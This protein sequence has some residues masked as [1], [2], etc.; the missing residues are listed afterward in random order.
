M[1]IE[2]LAWRT[3]PRKVRKLAEHSVAIVC[4]RLEVPIP[5]VEFYESPR[6]VTEVDEKPGVV[7]LR[8]TSDRP[9]ETL[10]CAAYQLRR[11]WCSREVDEYPDR[12]VA[13]ARALVR[14]LIPPE[15]LRDLEL[16]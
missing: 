6:A 14:E 7:W 11:I 3:V 12:S 15:K 4:Q 8:A 16:L 10:F 2:P 5:P 1:D 13:W 9:H